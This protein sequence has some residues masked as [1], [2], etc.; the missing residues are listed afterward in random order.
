MT[1]LLLQAQAEFGLRGLHT[2]YLEAFPSV[3]SSVSRKVLKKLLLIGSKAINRRSF[4][5]P[6]WTE[7]THD[8]NQEANF[9]FLCT[10]LLWIVSDDAVLHLWS[11]TEAAL[12][13]C[14]PDSNT[15]L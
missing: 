2:C 6:A 12:G 15:D 11:S 3:L 1:V 10:V 4:S 8:K 14:L 5:R 13:A 7:L 9:S